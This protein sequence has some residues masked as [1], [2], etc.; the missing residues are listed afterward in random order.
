MKHSNH[1]AAFYELLE[2]VT[3]ECEKFMADGVSGPRPVY[4]VGLAAVKGTTWPPQKG[5][6]WTCVVWSVV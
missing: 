1:S 2:T 5:G 4:V 6:G 3:T